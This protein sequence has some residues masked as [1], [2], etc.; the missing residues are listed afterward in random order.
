MPVSSASTS[1]SSSSKETQLQVVGDGYAQPF[2]T[3]KAADPAD[4]Q[5]HEYLSSLNSQRAA[6]ILYNFG[7]A[8]YKEK[9]YLQAFKNFEKASNSLRGN[10]KLWYYLGL[11]VLHLNKQVEQ[12][13][14]AHQ[15][16]GGTYSRAYG[17]QSPDFEKLSSYNHLN[18]FQLAPQGDNLQ[19]LQAAIAE[20]EAEYLSKL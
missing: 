3:N 17:M 4:A 14:N 10:P 15:H 9:K 20:Q 7:L 16:S 5:P 2:A 11:S 13:L 18:R 12:S 19:R 8:L 1:T 6:E